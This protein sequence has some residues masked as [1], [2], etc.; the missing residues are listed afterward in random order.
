MELTRYLSLNVDRLVSGG[1][2]MNPSTEDILKAVNETNGENI[3]I[4]PNNSNIILAAEQAKELSEK[5]VAVIPTKTIP[6]GISALLAFDET[7]S[8]EENIESMS[9][10]IQDVKTG[11][12]T[13][14]V[15]DTEYNNTIIN[16]DDIIGIS[17]GDIVAN[18]KDIN[19]VSLELGEQI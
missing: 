17:E 12:V 16:K 10:A 15:R 18:G 11:Q 13:Y 5:N 7:K 1:Q 6:Q 14:S 4:L 2:T 19:L 3:F 9:E 8:F